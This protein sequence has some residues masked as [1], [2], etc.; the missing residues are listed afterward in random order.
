M[1][2]VRAQNLKSLKMRYLTLNPVNATSD[3]TY[4]FKNGLPLIRFD[5]S[6]TQAPMLMDG[7]ALR[8][9]G[10]FTARKGDLNK[11]T[12]T[13]NNFVDNYAGLF[14]SCIQNITIA[15]KRLNQTLERVTQYNRLVPSIVS[16][17]NNGKYIDTNLSHGG[18]HACTI[19][20]L[21]HALNT[22][23]AFNESGN[24]VAD[25]N[26][27]GCD[28]SAPLYCG[29]L[30]TGEDI[31]LSSVTGVGGLTI[32]ILLNSD[33]NV[34]F[35]SDANTD[36][37]TFTLSDLTLTV[38]V[39][40]MGGEAAQNYAGQTNQYMF[41]SW[42][43]M[44]QTLNSSTSVVAFTPGLSRV[45]SCLQNYITSADL[46]DQ[47]YNSCRLGYPGQLQQV[48]FSKNGALFPLQFRLQSVSQQNDDKARP[49]P[50]VNQS[51]HTYKVL[52]ETTR[53]A[54][55]GVSSKKISRVKNTA[56]QF[57]D[58]AAGV[59]DRDQLSGRDGITPSTAFTSAI[60]YDAYGGGSDFS[61]EVFSME[62]K[63]SEAND[64]VRGIDNAGGVIGA[65]SNKIDGTSATAVA[66]HLYFLNQN[67]IMYSPQGIEL[68]R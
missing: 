26:Q 38:P 56:L 57:N 30:Q 40:E 27:T 51:S 13:E 20:Q 28:F 42:S 44:F 48:R 15:S 4:S 5:V 59:V 33:V 66:T 3:S 6:A 22:Y 19:P 37:A 23:H 8:I 29:M 64:L 25:A 67:T 60:L 21:R 47:R 68:R 65:T 45:T 46:G 39:Y 52:A 55:E 50:A 1:P 58:W 63:V 34:V 9:N 11:L 53:N 14:G 16:Q 61:Q 43:S 17:V 12:S 62:L 49:A 31:D 32:E 36:S 18:K 2:D 54:L 10:R 24:A 35:G 7:K 41:N